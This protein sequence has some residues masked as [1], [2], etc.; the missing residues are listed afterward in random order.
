ME[1]HPGMALWVEM[2]YLLVLAA[3]ALWAWR[4]YRQLTPPGTGAMVG[5][6]TSK[7]SFLVWLGLGMMVPTLFFVWFAVAMFQTPWNSERLS[8]TEAQRIIRERSDAKITLQQYKGAPKHLWIE[9]PESR[10]R[11]AYWT[12]ADDATLAVL[13]ATKHPYQTTEYADVALPMRWLPLLSMFVVPIGG[14]LLL[15]RPWKCAIDR[16]EVEVE[17]AETNA[18]GRSPCAWLWR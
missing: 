18:P 4:W 2:V 8:G 14:V 7:R 10:K 16:P 9:R 1:F 6:L 5:R 13:T 15:R 3:L 17:K 12:E 11:V